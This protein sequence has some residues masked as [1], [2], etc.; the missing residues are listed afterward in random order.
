MLTKSD[1]QSL[2]QCRRK[3]WLEH[4][5]PE[6]LPKDDSGLSRR[7]MDGVI[8]GEK[9]REQLGASYIWP[10]SGDEDMETAAAYAKKKMLA[11]PGQSAA[12]V[13]LVS[14]DLYARA[15]AL[16]PRAHGYVL[17][18]TKASTFP[19]KKDKQTIDSPKEHHLDDVA[20][21]QWVMEQ[22]G[23]AVA[24]VELNLLNGRWRYP[25]NN[26]YSGL[27][28]QLDVTAE[29]NLRKPK[30][31]LWLEQAKGVLQESMPAAVTGKQ[32]GDPY[33]CPF[34]GYCEKL[35]PTGPEAPIE[36]LPD[37][38]GKALAR[39]LRET[40]GYVSLLDPTPDEFVGKQAPLYQRM[41]K[42]HRTQQAIL[43][44]SA[45]SAL[46]ALGYPR[47]FFDFE[48]IDFP[49][50]QWKGFH[51]YEHAPFQWSCD[52]ELS[53]GQFQH[54]EFLDLTGNDPSLPCIEEMRQVI[55]PY[56]L[57]PIFVYS[58]AYERLRLEDLAVRHPEH[59]ELMDKYIARL[60]DLLPIV[61]E[62]F[63]HP[64]M[65]GS[66]SIK[67]VLPV[68]APDL[69]YQDLDEVQEGTAAQVAYLHATKGPRTTDERK[70]ELEKRLRIYCRQ[71]TWAM[72]EIAYFLSRQPRPRR[73][74]SYQ[75]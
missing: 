69:N 39:K 43:E 59:A 11:A 35:N 1:L 30:V 49:V 71:D 55:N 47:Y 51:P 60:V 10:R 5:K 68:I 42:A 44:P 53:P 52:I 64:A 54:A 14:G 61:K 48:G 20:I 23:L 26:D 27:F 41:Q 15:D 57:G 36:L 24:A 13:P 70:A 72:V 12:E 18:E 22:T 34:Q 73:P 21:Q 40:K 45:G 75:D 2:L 65:R 4:N 7:A 58:A 3:L 63:Y 50:P 25:G 38:A 62:N 19:L 9:A 28:R 16:V 29:S 46:Q 17:R 74:D 33:D 32:C 37:S 8:V 67:S 31:P 56:D 66:F 6:L